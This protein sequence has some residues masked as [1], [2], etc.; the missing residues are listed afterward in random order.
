MATDETVNVR[1]LV[2]DVAASIDFY[3]HHFGFSVLSSAAPA[4]ADV[5]RGNLRLLLSGPLSSAGRAVADGDLAPTLVGPTDDG[6]LEH[7]VVLVEHPF[8]LGAGDV[9]AAGDDHVLQAVDNEQVAVLVTH[10][11]VAGVEPAAGERLL[12]RRRVAPV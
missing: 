8:D 4:F 2:D 10:A 3:A 9:L 12:G 1:Y 5:K 7:G 6:H 11:D